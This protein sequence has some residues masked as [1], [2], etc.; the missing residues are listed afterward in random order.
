MK[1][2]KG[3]DAEAF[4]KA[5]E[6]TVHAR[7]VS[8]KQVA[9]TTGVSP[10]TLARM[11]TGRKPDAPSLAALCAW[12]GLNLADFVET[13]QKAKRPETVAVLGR[14]LK[15]DPTLTAK[16]A[17]ALESIFKAAYMTMRSKRK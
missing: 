13:D 1:H 6:A 15:A 7:Q 14:I 11:A 3:F 12:S 2:E 9:D 16:D 4:Y 17:E 10:T 8:W 5:V